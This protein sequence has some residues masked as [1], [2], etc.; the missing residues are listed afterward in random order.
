MNKA[1]L[2]PI[3]VISV[4]MIVIVI[5]NEPEGSSS[6]GEYEC[7]YGWNGTHFHQDCISYEPT[8]IGVVRI[9]RWGSLYG[10]TAF[11]Y[12][13]D[14]F[15]FQDSSTFNWVW[16]VEEEGEYTHLKGLNYFGGSPYSSF[17]ILQEYIFKEGEPVKIKQTMQNN[18]MDFNNFRLW[19]IHTMQQGQELSWNGTSYF[20][21]V[22]DTLYIH[23]NFNEILPEVDFHGMYLFNYSDLI[24]SGFDITDVLIGDAGLINPAG[25]GIPIMMV[26]VSLDDGVFQLG[27]IEVFDPTIDTTA[28]STNA[29][30]WAG[31]ENVARFSEAG[32]FGACYMDVSLGYTNFA[33]SSDYG[34]TWSTS[35]VDIQVQTCGV[36]IN[37]SDTAFVYVDSMTSFGTTSDLFIYSSD[38][39]INWTKTLAME[40]L[41]KNYLNPSGV[42]DSNDV[43]HLCST[44]LH[45]TVVNK[46]TELA[47]VNSTSW[48][49]EVLIKDDA[50]EYRLYCDVEVFTDNTVA[51]VSINY[52]TDVLEGYLSSDGF[53]ETYIIDTGLSVPTNNNGD[54]PSICIDDNDNIFIA[55]VKGNH[56]WVSIGQNPNNLSDSV[57][58]EI[59]DGTA[60]H[61]P[62]ISCNNQGVYVVYYNSSKTVTDGKFVAYSYVNMTENITN[63]ASWSV[64]NNL[65][66]PVAGF[67]YGF[68]T[69]ADS[70][71]PEF[72]RMTNRL[73][74]VYAYQD[75]N[76]FPY[77]YGVSFNNFTIPYSSCTYIEGWMKDWVIDEHCVINNEYVN[78]TGYFVNITATGRLNITNTGS[79]SASGY[80]L[81][82]TGWS[83]ELNESD[84][85]WF[86]VVR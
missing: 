25:S 28:H 71:Y 48:N 65:F 54:S 81:D 57:Q 44:A 38:N 51:L 77:R 66:T 73:D 72:N 64:G 50:G 78:V 47:Y 18:L 67:E 52:Q 3:L 23:G 39:Y 10:A 62:D 1:I 53:T 33:N 56:I 16:W 19:Y 58:I 79:L 69:V 32:K 74:F 4:F 36:L 63:P 34:Q 80:D 15:P 82:G 45:D 29:L 26:G 59:D 20:V 2:F 86:E 46:S 24:E 85:D 41:D 84:K 83:I 12:S 9:W 8:P 60:Y 13:V 17:P 43:I 68:P 61:Y 55:Y 5:A 49:N 37:S 31:K 35:L 30:I 14:G 75:T 70:H 22:N 27:D 42:L 7:P 40:D 76:G 11:G 21:D 6:I